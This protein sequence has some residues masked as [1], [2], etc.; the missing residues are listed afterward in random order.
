MHRKAAIRGVLVIAGALPFISWSLSWIGESGPRVLAPWFR[1]QCHGLLDRTLALSGRYFPV[2]SRCLGIYAG[3]LI[4]AV[5]ARPLLDARVRRGWLLAAATLMVLEV[6]VQDST[7]HRPYHALR[8]LTG[9]L[10]AW[11]V[12]LTLIAAATSES[13]R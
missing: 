9:I 4:A 6:F 3:L 8:L 11:P 2:C 7:G 12:A 10:L 13:D 5:V 1:F